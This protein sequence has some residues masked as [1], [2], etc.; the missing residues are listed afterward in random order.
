MTLSSQVYQDISGHKRQRQA[1]YEV[2]EQGMVRHLLTVF[3]TCKG[4]LRFKT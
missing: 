2:N 3:H 4:C 1:N